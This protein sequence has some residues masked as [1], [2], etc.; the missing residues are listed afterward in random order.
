[1][2]GSSSLSK[3]EKDD[4][5]Q[6]GLYDDEI[7]MYNHPDYISLFG[8]RKAQVIVR[9]IN[10]DRILKFINLK[11]STKNE[12]FQIIL[13][14]GKEKEMLFF[15][16]INILVVGPGVSDF[17]LHYNREFAYIARHIFKVYILPFF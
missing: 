3:Q 5:I 17:D 11:D 10:N 6:P 4:D 15:E 13:S 8:K 7:T 1:M 9:K 16:V 14:R 12:I 2:E